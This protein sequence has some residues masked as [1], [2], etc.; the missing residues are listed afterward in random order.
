MKSDSNI[1]NILKS[2]PILSQN[3]T[4]R[5][6]A[7]LI[8]ASEGS[9]VF[10]RFDSSV[11]GVVTEQ[12]ISAFI[13]SKD[14]TREALD[15]PIGPLSKPT[16][17]VLHPSSTIKDAA[18]A[19]GESD[20]DVLPVVDDYG[21][22]MGAIIR[23]D[24]ICILTDNLRP[25]SVGGMATPLG[26]FL[27]TGSHSGGAG[28]LGLILTGVS[29]SVMIAIASLV[30]YVLMQLFTHL[31]GMRVDLM[32]DS[33]P[34]ATTMSVYDLPYY[35]SAVLRSV[36]FL[37]LLRFS[38]LSGYHAAEHMTVHAIERGE[39]LTPEVVSQ[40]PRVHPRCGS[41]ILAI[42]GVFMI[43]AETIGAEAAVFAA[44][45][46][47]VLGWRKIGGFLQS[48]I[49][50]KTPSEKQLASGI[51]AG[52]EVMERFQANPGYQAFGFQRILNIGFLQTLLGMMVSFGLLYTL[53]ELLHINFLL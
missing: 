11:S 33:V 13:A 50:T 20:S 41:N 43:V 47:V 29:M 23:A 15:A 35:I 9:A 19:F 45:L 7:G 34:L 53:Q 32:L 27:T 18:E 48:A 46:V 44:V 38:P 51:A 36:I 42:A 39:S 16:T 8:K 52:K 2:A 40:M 17:A 31:T 30:S 5:R 1:L 3:D 49:T 22:F 4:I 6:A 12:S 25:P 28:A 26:V 24:V 10:V 37:A 14:D 21:T